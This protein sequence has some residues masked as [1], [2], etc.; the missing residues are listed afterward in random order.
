MYNIPDNKNL[1][2]LPSGWLT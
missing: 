1:G 2:A